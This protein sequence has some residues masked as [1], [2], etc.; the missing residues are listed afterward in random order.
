[1]V[2]LAARFGSLVLRLYSVVFTALA[3]AIVGLATSAH[4][5]IVG[6]NPSFL[7]SLIGQVGSAID[8]QRIDHVSVRAELTPGDGRLEAESTLTV[9][10]VDSARRRFFCLLNP[11]LS[12]AEVSVRDSADQPLGF[13]SYRLWMLQAVELDEPLPAGETVRLGFRYGGRPRTGLF[14][15]GDAAIQSDYALLG[16]DSFWFPSDVHGFFTADVE[17]TAP[18]SLTVLHNG[19]PVA[20]V[21]RGGLR[22]TKWSYDRPVAS[23]ALAA[24]RY[25]TL[26]TEAD[27]RKLRL[28]LAEDVELDGSQILEH[29]AKAKQSLTDLFGESGFGQSSVFVSR[30]LRRAFNDGSGLIG[31]SIRYF[32]GGDYGFSLIAHEIAHDWWGAT[33]AEQW[34]KPATGGEWLVEGFATFSSWLATEA[35]YGRSGLALTVERDIFDPERQGIIRDMSAFDNLLNETMARDTIYRKGG[36]AA[37]MLRQRLGTDAYYAALRDFI[38]QYRLQQVSAD[39]L[40]QSLEASTGQDLGSFFEDWIDSRRLADL[41]FEKTA[42]GGLLLTNTGQARIESEIEVLIRSPGDTPLQSTTARVGDR[43]DAEGA[44]EIL[45]DPYLLWAD[46]WR[47]NNRFPVV[48]FPAAVAATGDG[49]SYLTTGDGFPWSRTNV[50]LRDA[51]GR[52]RHSWD[53]A[54][55][56]LRPPIVSADGSRA[57]VAL[58][59]ASSPIAT[60]VLLASDGTRRS[61]GSGDA[62]QFAADGSVVAARL[63]QIVA[64]GTAGGESTV[65]RRPGWILDTPLPAPQGHLFAYTAARGN[66]MELR[67]LDRASGRDRRLMTMDRDRI[68][69]AWS[70]DSG[71][72]YAAFGVN[73]DWQI[74]ALPVNGDKPIT[75][76]TGIAVLNAVALSPGGKR[77]AF[78]GVADP[79]FPHLRSS[80]YV[81]DVDTRSVDPIVVAGHDLERISW[82]DDDGLLAVARE[83]RP[84]A[85]N[86]L[87][88]IR[89]LKRFDLRDHRQ[90]DAF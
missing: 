50:T 55:G 77:L 5:S 42:D 38:R 10:A 68:W 78:T 15:S 40:R 9:A 65:L 2:A 84:E 45:L 62:P 44:S 18:A 82:I 28:H 71:R 81:L 26:E 19:T 67:L 70:P 24:G 22:A 4:L 12:L 87:P 39:M 80:L 23:F 64:F 85:D 3:L 34:L 30:R 16:P 53:F 6:A 37:L 36:Y 31:T 1:M 61:L 29:M 83:I 76:A 48:A 43:I 17:I 33:V 13:R 35:R 47:Q 32:R 46:P 21:T 41:T 25:R 11:A 63:D 49:S 69:L 72:L 59:E 66:E 86:T 75:L 88:A 58:S 51:D 54:R 90:T 79:T 20:E 73:W 74:L 7:R 89:K 60:M 56:F 8:G 57:L 27:G 14:G 52:Q